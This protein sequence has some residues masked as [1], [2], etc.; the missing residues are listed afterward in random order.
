MF[1]NP[2]LPQTLREQRDTELTKADEDMYGDYGMF[3][4]AFLSWNAIKFVLKAQYYSSLKFMRK[5]N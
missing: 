3:A 5:L 1:L 2:V 4:E